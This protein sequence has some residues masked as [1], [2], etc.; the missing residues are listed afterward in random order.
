MADQRTALEAAEGLHL[1]CAASKSR[2]P[3][4]LHRQHMLRTRLPQTS[5]PTTPVPPQAHTHTTHTLGMVI[6]AFT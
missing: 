3:H 5:T 4:T 1:G 6:T 2:L